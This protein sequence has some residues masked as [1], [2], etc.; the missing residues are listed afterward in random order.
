MLCLLTLALLA[1]GEEELEK[2][3]RA[4][5][6]VAV[7]YND[8]VFKL[9]DKDK[10]KLLDALNVRLVEDDVFSAMLPIVRVKFDELSFGVIG[11]SGKD[12]SRTLD[13]QGKKG[14]VSVDPAL[15]EPLNEILGKKLGR[16]VDVTKYDP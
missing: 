7:V 14:Q 10:K 13:L 1:A 3:C 4:A 5:K 8:F 6:T 2:Q 15:I 16:K 12:K 11:V 9:D